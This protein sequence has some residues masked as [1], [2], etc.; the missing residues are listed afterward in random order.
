MDKITYYRLFDKAANE[1]AS[2]YL[3]AEQ[4]ARKF[5]DLWE[6]PPSMIADT[7]F[8]F[9]AYDNDFNLIGRV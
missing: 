4:A 9:W 5:P 8:E 6:L 3:T 7:D 1:W 2:D